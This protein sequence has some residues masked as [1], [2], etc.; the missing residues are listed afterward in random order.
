MAA[1]STQGAGCF[2]GGIASLCELLIEHKEAIEYDLITSAGIECSEVGGSLSMGAFASFVKGLSFD[3]ALWRSQHKD[4]VIWGSTLKTNALLADIYDLLA[5][6]NANMC[7][8][9]SHKK[10]SKITP[11]PRPWLADNTKR[12]GGK[13]A[14][15]KNELREWI[16]NYGKRS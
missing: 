6:M 5:Q 4:T 8:G 10:A 3:S 13:G 1:H 15:P 9:F 16:K 14:L 2:I 12:I 7:G 11:L